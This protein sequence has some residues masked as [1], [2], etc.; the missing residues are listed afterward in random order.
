MTTKINLKDL[1][2]SDYKALLNNNTVTEKLIERTT[3]PDILFASEWLSDLDGLSDYSLGGSYDHNYMVVSDSYKLLKSVLVAQRDYS[4]L[5]DALVEKIEKTLSDYEDAEPSELSYYDDKLDS[6]SEKIADVL[7]ESAKDEI[8]CLTSE[9]GLLEDMKTGMLLELYNDD[10]YY[11]R[12][13]N[14]VYH[15]CAD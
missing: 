3:D 14:K 6:V 7:V 2:D 5:S 8:D 9:E 10:A 12:E 15:I 11:N 13:D 4:L 1:K